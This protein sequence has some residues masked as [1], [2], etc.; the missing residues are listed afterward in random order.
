M[1]RYIQRSLYK[2]V[3]HL[4]CYRRIGLPI[5]RLVIRA[6][7]YSTQNKLGLHIER[8]TG[9]I[10]DYIEQWQPAVVVWVGPNWE[11]IDAI[12]ERSP[13][14]FIVIRKHEEGRDWNSNAPPEQW[15]DEVMAMVT[16][17]GGMVHKPDAAV[18]WTGAFGHDSVELFEPFDKWQVAYRE[19]L[20]NRY[21]I[22]AVLMCFYTG[23]FNKGDPDLIRRAFPQS[24]EVGKY[25]GLQEY[26]W[27][28]MFDDRAIGWHTV[29]WPYWVQ[30][31]GREDIKI[32]VTEC[33]LTQAVHEGRLDVGYR[34]YED[35][36]TD[37]TYLWDLDRYNTKLVEDHKVIGAAIFD[38]GNWSWETFEHEDKP[39]L[40]QR[41]ISISALVPP[42]PP[43]PNGGENMNI[44]VFDMNNVEQTLD[45]AI[46]KYGVAFRRAEV[47]SGQK[48][49][50]LVELREKSGPASLVT[51]VVNE[52]G[53]PIVNMDVAFYWP[54]APEPPDPPTAVLPHDWY[55]NFV[56]GPTNVN[57][58]I[59]PGMGPG[60]Y[61][62]E[63][64]GGPHA[65]WVRDPDIPSDI[66]EK[67][68]ML[69]GT[70]HDHLDQ[71]FKLQTVGEG[72][73]PEPEGE[74]E[75]KGPPIV[76]DWD[77]NMLFIAWP[78][79]L[80][81]GADVHATSPG[82]DD[83]D[84][85]PLEKWEPGKQYAI[86][87]VCA[88]FDSG[89]AEPR[90]YSIWAYRLPNP[91]DRITPVVTYK[92]QPLSQ[93]PT[94]KVTYIVDYKGGEPPPPSDDQ[95]RLKEIATEMVGN[96]AEINEIADRWP[97]NHS[98]PTELTLHFPDGDEKYT[99]SF[100]KASL[101]NRLRTVLTGW[102][103]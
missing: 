98:T 23:N 54:G 35:G 89:A 33:G 58:D 93:I 75:I 44:R 92:F 15:A 47:E 87:G 41:I 74:L 40:V 51:Q 25:F 59:G 100:V 27:P 49:Y 26:Y 94:Q 64:E 48:V 24:C 56:H 90:A 6:L 31:I 5:Q 68:G 91:D 72:P 55:R 85:T 43:E 7:G 80:A 63:G 46:A 19:H 66:C 4:G 82:N 78:I 2:P 69:A 71:K 39:E 95:A 18:A 101:L 102:G 12:R 13:G 73:G 45:W 20:V 70:P 22:E 3:S 38:W 1:K 11:G 28:S 53:N 37:E 88:D 103:R 65:V 21:D 76:T 60:A 36:V 32:I 61:H 99:L 83:H 62:G 67:L 84:T 81:V 57:G 42:E 34:T 16:D 30:A 52:A 10:L 77:S 14:T 9:Q 96:A 50:R 86:A 8:L 29:R 79:A 17:G 97:G